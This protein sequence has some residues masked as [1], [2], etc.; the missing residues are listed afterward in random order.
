MPATKKHCICSLVCVSVGEACS[1]GAQ[2]QGVER[3]G[4]SVRSPNRFYVPPPIPHLQPP[5][6]RPLRNTPLSQL[7]PHVPIPPP[8]AILPHATMKVPQP[9]ETP[10][11]DSGRFEWGWGWIQKWKRKKELKKE[12]LMSPTHY[13]QKKRMFLL[14][15]KWEEKEK[16]QIDKWQWVLVF[17]NTSFFVIYSTI[18][19]AKVLIAVCH[20]IY[21]FPLLAYIWM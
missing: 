15:F 21:K 8:P 4:D 10:P 6:P 17:V 5:P 19:A 7:I 2:E 18:Q 20:F 11:R 1:G 3:R 12:K 16:N 14:R 13:S 9:D